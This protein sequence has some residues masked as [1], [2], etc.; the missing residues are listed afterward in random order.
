VYDQLQAE[1]ID[2]IF[3][4]GTAFVLTTTLGL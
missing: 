4:I 2:L 1:G 3:E